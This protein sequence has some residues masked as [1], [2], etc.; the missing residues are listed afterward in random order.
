MVVLCTQKSLWKL[1]FYLVAVQTVID[2][3][4]S[5]VYAL[6]Y[7]LGG[8]FL[9]LDD[10]CYNLRHIRSQYPNYQVESASPLFPTPKTQPKCACQPART[11]LSSVFGS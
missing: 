2:L 9:T 5:G 7:H 8:V 11:F 4:F 6:I 1:D 10:H 3:L